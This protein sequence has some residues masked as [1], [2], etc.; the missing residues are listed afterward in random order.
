MRPLQCTQFPDLSVHPASSHESGVPFFSQVLAIGGLHLPSE[1][2]HIA[3]AWLLQSLT[4]SSEVVY[5]TDS[6]LVS[7]DATRWHIN[8][9]SHQ[10]CSAYSIRFHTG[11]F[12][13]TVRPDPSTYAALPSGPKGPANIQ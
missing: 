1:I 8:E 9:Y 2:L 5:H 6:A 7:V 10:T 11:L 4:G 3:W 13:R 12:L